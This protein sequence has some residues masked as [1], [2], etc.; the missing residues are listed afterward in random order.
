MKSLKQAGYLT[1]RNQHVSFNSSA[2]DTLGIR[3]GVPQGSILGPLLFLL[4]MNDITNYCD[5]PN[6]QFVLYAND[7]NIFVVGSC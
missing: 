2:S 1:G 3:Y 5:D 4:Y 7:T 6:V